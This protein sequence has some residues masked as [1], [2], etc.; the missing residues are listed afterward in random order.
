M[1]WMVVVCLRRMSSCCQ[2]HQGSRMDRMT[3]LYQNS[4]RCKQ[5]SQCSSLTNKIWMV[6]SSMRL[7][8]NRNLML[9]SRKPLSLILLLLKLHQPKILRLRLQ[10]IHLPINRLLKLLKKRQRQMM[11]VTLLQSNEQTIF[12]YKGKRKT[13]LP[14][15]PIRRSKK[16][17]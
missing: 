9:E 13:N 15:D 5:L 8:S 17:L 4:T 11:A 10:R 7:S 12:S 6:S 3:E 1:I 2:D 16:L 14:K